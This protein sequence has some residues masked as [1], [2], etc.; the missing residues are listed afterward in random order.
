MLSEIKLESYAYRNAIN[1]REQYTGTCDKD[2]VMFFY[3]VKGN[4]RIKSTS[5]AENVTFEETVSEKRFCAVAPECEYI[6]TAEKNASFYQLHFICENDDGIKSY[7]LNSEYAEKLPY[8]KELISE[9]G[10]FF[11]LSDTQNVRD[12]MNKLN[13]CLNINS[14]NSF[15]PF[16]FDLKLKEFFLEIL[17]CYRNHLDCANHNIFIR[18]ALSY[19]NTNFYKNVT[20][21][22]IAA[23]AKLS[24]SHLQNLFQTHM[25]YSVHEYLNKTRVD[26]S[27]SLLI[28]TNYS[29]NRIA[30][31]VGYNSTQVFIQNFKKNNGVSPSKYKTQEMHSP[32]F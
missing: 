32:L 7:L 4:I 31:E 28:N 14:P 16:S 8:S 1:E 5:A 13:D 18:K 23:H 30:K 25:G 3:T 11:S 26:R 20:L 2:S 24:V 29:I 9:F 17:K 27:C 19:I 6:L 22:E 12:S 10:C 15:L 21:D